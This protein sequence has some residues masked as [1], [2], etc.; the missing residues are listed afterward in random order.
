MEISEPKAREEARATTKLVVGLFILGGFLL[1]AIS[2]LLPHDG[3]A[4]YF[5]EFLKELGI[6]ILSV[7]AISLLYDARFA[8]FEIAFQELEV[9][10]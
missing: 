7:F 8:H 4:G 3:I 1:I 6:V 5:H 9:Q 10:F 2:I